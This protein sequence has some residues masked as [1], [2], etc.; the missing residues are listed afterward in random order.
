MKKLV[1]LFAAFGLILAATGLT[2]A[3][4]V[5]FQFDPNDLLGNYASTPG[6]EYDPSTYKATQVDARR[7][8]KNIS[9]GGYYETFYNPAAPHSQPNDYNTYVNWVNGLGENEGIASFNMWMA[10]NSPV[11]SWGETLVMAPGSTITAT[12]DLGNGWFVEVID[13]SW[14]TGY[15]IVRWYTNDPAN[16]LRPNGNDIGEFSFTVDVNVDDDGNGWD[17]DDPDPVVGETY[18]VWLGSQNGQESDPDKTG[19]I[20]FDDQG[21]GVLPSTIDPFSSELSTQGAPYGTSWE[22]ALQLTACAV[23]EASSILVWTLL[24]GLAV[25]VH[26]RR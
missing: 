12:S 20:F 19:A 9:T 8:F 5:T 24:A 16:Y 2:Q 26:R 23:P 15:A 4:V 7:I 11:R 10:N 21:W 1:V 17:A 13:N 6:D 25:L 18:R 22:G 14:I 3:A